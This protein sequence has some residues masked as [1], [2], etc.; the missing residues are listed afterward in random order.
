MIES[1]TSYPAQVVWSWQYLYR[2]GNTIDK[3]AMIYLLPLWP[4]MVSLAI[5][6]FETRRLICQEETEQDRPGKG[7][8]MGAVAVRAGEPANQARAAEPGADAVGADRW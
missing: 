5:I 2:S 6:Y 1:I 7:P 8:G 4:I 3:A